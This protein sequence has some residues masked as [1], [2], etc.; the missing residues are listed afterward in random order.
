MIWIL[1]QSGENSSYGTRAIEENYRHLP[2]LGSRIYLG[3]REGMAVPVT[4]LLD[5]CVVLYHIKA[6][7]GQIRIAAGTVG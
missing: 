4:L 3:W 6:S 7:Q 1:H 5:F 2:M